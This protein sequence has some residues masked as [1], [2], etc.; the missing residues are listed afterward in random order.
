MVSADL[1]HGQA[2]LRDK[3]ALKWKEAYCGGLDGA[4][5]SEGGK[6]TGL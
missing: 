4:E 5:E 1:L 3:Q 2:Q 6:R